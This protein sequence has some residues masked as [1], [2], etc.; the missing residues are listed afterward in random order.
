M[1]TL[2]RVTIALF[3]LFAVI[4]AAGQIK[5]RFF[6]DNTPPVIS[7]ST[8]LLECSVTDGD[9]VL[10]ADVSAT[11]AHDGDVTASLSVMGVSGLVSRDTAI[12]SYIA[13][14]SS[15]NM[16]I[17]KRSIRYTD[18]HKPVFA[19]SK[20]LLYKS[21]AAI[22]LT[23]RV[24]AEDVLDGDITDSIRVTAQDLSVSHEGEYSITLQVTNSAGDSSVLPLT[25]IINNNAAVTHMIRLSEYLVYL[26][27]GTEFDPMDYVEHV[28]GDAEGISISSDL[29]SSEPGVYEVRYSC[30]SSGGEYTVILTVVVE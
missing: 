30:P 28:R 8:E 11:D 16:S 24:T 29:D 23:D 6:T 9:D 2:K 21:G 4:F 14:D 12:V 15:N 1:R 13:F 20:P 10:L 7:C 22:S 27:A 3:A 19:I 18:Y 25:V 5:D 26:P 17:M